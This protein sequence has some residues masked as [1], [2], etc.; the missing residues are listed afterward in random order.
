MQRKKPD[1]QIFLLGAERLGLDPKD[2]LVVEDAVNGIQAAKAAGC[3]CLGITTSFGAAR[4]RTAGA[5]DTAPNLGHAEHV[6]R[7]ID[8]SSGVVNR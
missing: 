5:D 2:C 4:L 3:C 8:I 7:G 6:L 1:P